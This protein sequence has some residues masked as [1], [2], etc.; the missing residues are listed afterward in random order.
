M[1]KYWILLVTLLYLPAHAGVIYNYIE[2][3]PSNG[4]YQYSGS[5]EVSHEAFALGSVSGTQ[6]YYSVCDWAATLVTCDT[7][8]IHSIQMEAIGGTWGDFDMMWFAG[9]ESNNTSVW[10]ELIYHLTFGE[11]LSGSFFWFDYLGTDLNMSGGNSW[12][13]NH[14]GSDE[15]IRGCMYHDAKI[16]QGATGYWQLDHSSVSIPEP[17]GLLV[18]V[19]A[20][21]AWRCYI[22][23]AFANK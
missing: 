20:L 4:G 2:T 19:L 5:I 17:S 12:S 1:K 13:I 9:S 6:D 14:S 3:S 15:I 23:R 16:C 8:T 10:G 7:P 11:R 18:M 21:F 22:V